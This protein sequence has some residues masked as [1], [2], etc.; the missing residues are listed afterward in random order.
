MIRL[1]INHDGNPNTPDGEYNTNVIEVL[2]ETEF[3]VLPWD[4]FVLGT[5]I[6][7]YGKEVDDFL[8]IDKPLIGLIAAGAC[9]TLSQQV[10]T[11]QSTLDAVLLKYPL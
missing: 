5:D 9:K 1:Y 10:S 2:S 7:I 11:L 3:K 4:K 8:G 6:F